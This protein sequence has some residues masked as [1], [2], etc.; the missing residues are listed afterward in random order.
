MSSYGAYSPNSGQSTTVSVAATTTGAPGSNANVVNNGTP[1]AAS[2][3]FTIPA[4]V[5]WFT[6]SGAPLTGA[7][8]GDLYLDLSTGDI[9]RNQ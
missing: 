7:N 8:T 6:G 3:A 9:Y 5:N 2:L 4:G 1:S